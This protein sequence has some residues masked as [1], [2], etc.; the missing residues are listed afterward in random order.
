MLGFLKNVLATWDLQV[1]Y[2]RAIQERLLE[3]T[4]AGGPQAVS[5]DPDHWLPLGSIPFTE[6]QRSDMR[7]H[8]RRLVRE[9]PHAR[10]ILRLLESYVTGPGLSLS[11]Q[12]VDQPTKPICPRWRIAY[13]KN[14]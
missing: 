9:N 6:P 13:G 4:E 11:H 12:P 14:S 5:E 10:N 2:R 3:L 7:L 8:A 1:R